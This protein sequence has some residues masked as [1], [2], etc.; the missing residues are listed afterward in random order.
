M[1]QPPQ[2]WKQGQKTNI[3]EANVTQLN[4]PTGSVSIVAETDKTTGSYTVYS[5]QGINFIGGRTPMYTKSA[6]GATTV[7]NKTLYDTLKAQGDITKLDNSIKPRAYEIN[8]TFGTDNEKKTVSESTLYKSEVNKAKQGTTTSEQ[9]SAAVGESKQGTRDKFPGA[10]TEEPLRYPITLKLQKQDV[11]M[12]KMV[13]YSPKKLGTETE[14]FGFG[15]RN[16]AGSE[17]RNIIGRVVLPIPGGISDTNA[18]TWGGA[19]MNALESAL[20]SAGLGFIEGGAE[21]GTKSFESSLNTVS[22]NSEDVK[23]AIS[24]AFAGQVVGVQGLLTRT[25]GLIINPNMELL[26]QAPTLRPFTFNFKLSAR[27]PEEAKVIRSIIRFF[28]QGMAPIR[29]KSNLFL[30]SPHTFQLEYLH[31]YEP[32]TYLNKFKECALTYFSVDYTPEGQYATFTDGA[33]VSYQITMQF[34]ELEP[35]FNDDYK[36][37]ENAPDTEIGY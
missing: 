8:Q 31:K 3:Y 24:T 25:T 34:Q 28:K 12:F 2:G 27:S 23:K 21:A 18:V 16:V 9:I 11:I 17:N 37:P 5:T 10:G 19:D 4:I 15:E 6:S 1:A 26:F 20:G 22:K 36:N 32:H 7:E 30:K 35:V 33:M 13:Q 29:T 14:T